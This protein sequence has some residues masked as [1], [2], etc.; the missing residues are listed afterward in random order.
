[1][2]VTLRS[3]IKVPYERDKAADVQVYDPTLTG[4]EQR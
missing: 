3:Q 4:S 1:M 2:L